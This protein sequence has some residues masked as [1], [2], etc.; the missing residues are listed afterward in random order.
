MTASVDPKSGPRKRILF[1]SHCG[2]WGG[3]QKVLYLL[4]SGLDQS[5]FEPIIIV[6]FEGPLATA[7]RGINADVIVRPVPWWVGPRGDPEQCA[8]GFSNGFDAR[9][10]SLVE[11]I[12]DRQIDVVFSNTLVIADG[13]I[14]ASKAGVPH[15]WQALEMLSRDPAYSPPISLSLFYAIVTSLSDTVVAVSIAVRDEIGAYGSTTNV[16]VIHTGLPDDPAPQAVDPPAP[17]RSPTG[18]RATFVGA[19]QERKGVGA[20]VEAAALVLRRH[21]AATFSIVGPDAGCLASVRERISQLGLEKQ[22]CWLGERDDVGQILEESNVFVLPAIA[23]PLP[24]VVL[25]AMQAGV[26]VV[27]T[28]SGGCEEMVIDGETGYL[29]PIG[30]VAALADR[31]C[32]LLANPTAAAEMG[33]NG[34]RRFLNHFSYLKFMKSVTAMLLALDAQPRRNGADTGTT[35]LTDTIRD[36]YRIAATLSTERAAHAV[37]CD[38]LQARITGMEDSLSWR[39]TAPIRRVLDAVRKPI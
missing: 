13:A 6:P 30:D 18:Q 34:R 33:V 11:L 35:T 5:Q 22:V 23:D 26:P 31:L 27:A 9:I 21:P 39:C 29:V 8:V 25:E 7:L 20:L 16:K 24:L 10:E 4:V 3:A 38:A 37:M 15:V 28:A 2:H 36:A 14:A 19:L 12:V 17:R 32:R 1:L